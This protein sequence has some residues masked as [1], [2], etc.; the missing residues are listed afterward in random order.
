MTCMATDGA[1]RARARDLGIAPGPFPPGQHN[2]ITDVPG[3]R[4]G[5]ETVISGADIRTG[6]TVVLPH[7]GN[8]YQQKV[9][10]AVAVGNG[11]AK[12]AG[13]I[14]VG[15]LGTIETP[16]VLTN[17]LAVAAGTGRR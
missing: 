8:L 14:Q 15:E 16:I 11:F 5:Q 17:T 12:T 3:V 7:P 4:V 10:G 6:V 13:S 2:A 1:N 9:P